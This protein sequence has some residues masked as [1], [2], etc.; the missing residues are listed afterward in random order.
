MKTIKILFIIIIVLLSACGK[1]NINTSLEDFCNVKPE[2]WE[3]EIIENNFNENDI[4]K[5]TKDPIAIIKYRNL[6]REF[7]R[8][9]QDVYPSLILDLYSIKDKRELKKFISSQLMYSW[10]IPTYYGENR[11]FFV[12]TS[13]CFINYGSFTEEADSSIID[14]HN[15]LENILS[16]KDYGF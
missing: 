14:L 4:P 8:F 1:D 3:C 11:D 7:T 13:P 2:G 16:K 9:G 10:C 15:S 6:S 5:N 12:I